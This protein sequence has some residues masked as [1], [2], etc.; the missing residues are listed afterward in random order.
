MPLGGITI[1]D[2]SD[3]YLDVVPVFPCSRV[4]SF[5]VCFVRHTAI[6][7]HFSSKTTMTDY[8][9]DLFDFSNPT[10]S[11]LANQIKREAV[12][13]SMFPTCASSVAV[14]EMMSSMVNSL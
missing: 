14:N 6:S 9:Q 3:S 8:R 2:I 13:N 7:V 11:S 10:T 5:H 12:P 1:A 4:I